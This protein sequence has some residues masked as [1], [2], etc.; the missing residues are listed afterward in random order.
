M[1]YYFLNHALM[2]HYKPKYIFRVYMRRRL[3]EIFGSLLRR[4][5][6]SGNFTFD[7]YVN[8]TVSENFVCDRSVRVFVILQK[9]KE[10]G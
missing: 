3:K 9:K 7:F 4:R 1:G 8:K 10:R 5:R 2:G 6:L